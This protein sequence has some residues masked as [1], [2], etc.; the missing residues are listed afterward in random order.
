MTPGASDQAQINTELWEDGDYVSVYANR[1][2][3]PVEVL[4]LARYREAL[5]GRVLEVGCGGGRILGYLVALAA[6]AHGIDISP[7]MVAYCRREYPEATVSLGDVGALT[8]TVAG[9]FDAILA[10]GTLIDVFSD[11]ERRRVLVS[12]RELIVPGGLLIFSSHN[13]ASLDPPGEPE[14]PTGGK[15]GPGRLLQQIVHKPPVDLVRAVVRL[16]RRRRNRRRLA[17][18]AHREADHAIVNDETFDYGLLHY[19]IGREDQERQLRQLGYDPVAC[20][21]PSGRELAP[22]AV[23]TAPWL[24]YISRPGPDVS[25]PSGAVPMP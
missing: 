12:L 23:S 5:S 8:D 7:A 18:L 4:I 15:A 2:L 14:P 11:E 21:D 9:K 17:P 22:G 3:S 20:L 10:M 19:Y 25:S 1:R 13:L 24:H 16:P 6:E